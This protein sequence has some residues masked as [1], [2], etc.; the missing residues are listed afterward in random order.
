[1]ADMRERLIALMHQKEV[2]CHNAECEKCK[3]H[4]STLPCRLEKIFDYLIEN[5]VTIVEHGGWK[6]KD[7][8]AGYV[9]I[10]CTVCKET[11]Y[12]SKQALFPNYCHACGA[13]MDKKE[14]EQ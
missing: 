1:M 11:L 7:H 12:M 10:E 5:G 3:Y 2:E 6:I 8:G 14:R 9:Q 4:N 13:K